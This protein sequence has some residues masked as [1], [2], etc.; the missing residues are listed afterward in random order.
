MAVWVVTLGMLVG[1]P[2]YKYTF[3]LGDVMEL[4]LKPTIWPPVAMPTGK[5]APAAMA[6]G[7]VPLLMILGGV[8]LPFSDELMK[9]PALEFCVMVLAVVATTDALGPMALMATAPAVLALVMT[10]GS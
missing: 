10:T 7:P 9:T 6:T 4:P 5:L 2:A 1:S 3:P 8:T